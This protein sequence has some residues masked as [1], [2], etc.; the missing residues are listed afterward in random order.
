MGYICTL[1][2]TTYI[3]FKIKIAECYECNKKNRSKPLQTPH[4]TE[5]TPNRFIEF[6]T[7]IG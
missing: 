2:K 1:N 3:F 4:K 6:P 7:V 5:I